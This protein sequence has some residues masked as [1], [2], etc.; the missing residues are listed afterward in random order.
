[1]LFVF[2]YCC[3]KGCLLFLDLSNIQFLELVGSGAFGQVFKAVWR[4]TL[5]A[6]KVVLGNGKVVQNEL[7]VYK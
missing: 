6:A 4:G 3:C 2:F 5:V 1:M 7:S